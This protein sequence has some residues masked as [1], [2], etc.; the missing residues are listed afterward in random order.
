MF[1]NSLNAVFS[2]KLNCT[3]ICRSVGGGN[4]HHVTQTVL[5]P[6]TEED[7]DLHNQKH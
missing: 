1:D 5:T 2:I 3:I 6:T 4:V 7:E